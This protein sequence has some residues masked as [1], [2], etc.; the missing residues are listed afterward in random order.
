MHGFYLLKITLLI[1]TQ[2]SRVRC[3]SREEVLHAVNLDSRTFGHFDAKVRFCRMT[4][5]GCTRKPIRV[6][7]KCGYR[8]WYRFMP[9]TF[10]LPLK[11]RRPRSS[12]CYAT[13]KR[14]PPP[15]SLPV[16]NPSF[17][18]IRLRIIRTRYARSHLSHVHQVC[19]KPST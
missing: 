16:T 10:A 3:E 14:S 9:R 12:R 17:V 5:C 13:R 15:N 7:I 8:S 6:T 4:P 11:R 2:P 19:T 1:P 18:S